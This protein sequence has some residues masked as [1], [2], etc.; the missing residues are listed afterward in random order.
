[1]D[2]PTNRGSDP[3]EKCVGHG[4]VGYIRSSDET[5]IPESRFRPG[6]V[7]SAKSRPGRL[8]SVRV[9]RLAKFT[10]FTTPSLNQD[11]HTSR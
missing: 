2:P 6:H 8:P 11:N 4:R 7:G 9:L 5:G 3:P 10:E 1:M